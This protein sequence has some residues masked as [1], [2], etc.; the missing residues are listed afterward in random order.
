MRIRLSLD[1]K[2]MFNAGAGTRTAVWTLSYVQAVAIAQVIVLV[3]EVFPP[4][5]NPTSW[6]ESLM[7]QTLSFLTTQIQ[8][9]PHMEP[10]HPGRS[11]YM[12]YIG[13]AIKV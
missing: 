1:L 4:G 9:S 5:Q 11:G 7:M 13:G 10:E 8:L 3:Q 2:Y 12:Y 6:R